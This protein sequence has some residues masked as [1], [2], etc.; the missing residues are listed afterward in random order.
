MSQS[1]KRPRADTQSHS[2][3]QSR[4]PRVHKDRVDEDVHF[5][6]F[7]EGDVLD[8][9]PS[10]FD[11]QLSDCTNLSDG[12]SE[13]PPVSASDAESESESD[14]AIAAPSPS[15]NWDGV[16]KPRNGYVLHGAVENLKGPDIESLYTQ[17]VKLAKVDKEVMKKFVDYL[18]RNWPGRQ[19]NAD[20]AASRNLVLADPTAFWSALFV[21]EFKNFIDFLDNT[22][23]ANRSTRVG[24][25]IISE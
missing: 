20:L 9:D 4:K 18:V 19:L 22:P 6:L 14:E 23:A 12:G 21:P 2:S 7:D 17:P 1:Q 11:G 13:F 25:S 8:M 16:R 3:P 15:G 24:C 10:L 5:T